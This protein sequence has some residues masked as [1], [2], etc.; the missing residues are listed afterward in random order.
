MVVVLPDWGT[1][2]MAKLLWVLRTVTTVEDAN[3]V[4]LVKWDARVMVY[5]ISMDPSN[6]R[7]Q[8]V[9]CMIR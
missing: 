3:E 1:G 6:L 8:A 7:L 4:M 9:D 2:S 5:A